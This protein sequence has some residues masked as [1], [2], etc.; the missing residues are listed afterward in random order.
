MDVKAL[1]PPS[2]WNTKDAIRVYVYHTKE[3]SKTIL[4]TI[5][6]GHGNCSMGVQ[7]RGEPSQKYVEELQDQNLV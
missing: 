4:H 3:F 5:I 2:G 7:F 1:L 6:N